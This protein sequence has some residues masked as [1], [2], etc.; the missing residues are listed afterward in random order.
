MSI[1]V[2]S[3]RPLAPR[4][5]Q[6]P[7]KV[8]PA[9]ARAF[10]AAS[11]KK[12]RLSGSSNDP[13]H[14]EFAR[15]VVRYS[16]G[17][18]QANSAGFARMPYI[19]E[20]GAPATHFRKD[21]VHLPK[22]QGVRTYERDV[23]DAYLVLSGVLTVGWEEN[24]KLVEEQLGPRDLIFNPPGQPHRFVNKGVE[25]VQFM[26]VVGSGEPETTIFRPI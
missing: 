24:G 9:L 6:H 5:T 21:L 14:R 7:S 15:H 22:G 13:R 23:E 16:E 2:G 19:G 20:G 4:Y 8:D 11:G 1:M 12:Y 26:M 10:G 18:F 25:D 17:R 3:G